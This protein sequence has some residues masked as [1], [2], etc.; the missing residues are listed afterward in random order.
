MA[1]WT[2]TLEPYIKVQEEIKTTTLTPTAGENLIIGVALI[3]DAGPSTPTLI[4]GQKEF[5]KTYASQDLTQEYID[6]L[7]N[8]Y[9]GEDST[10]AATMWANA[11]RL[12]GSNTLLVTRAT[13]AD[14]I[15]FSKPLTKD[16]QNTYILRDGE[17]LKKIDSGFKLVLDDG[18]DAADH[19]TD[20]WSINI[21][22]VGIF[23]N[24]TTDEGA[25]Y[26]YFV[27][28]LLNN[29]YTNRFFKINRI[30]I[31]YFRRNRLG[32]IVIC[33]KEKKKRYLKNIF[34]F[35]IM[36]SQEGVEP[37]TPGL[38]GLCSI[39]LSY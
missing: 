6:S 26:D 17:L 2:Q 25:Q 34:S 12:A 30:I 35:Y 10:T 23:G 22:G 28:T 8:L 15:F 20:G 7:N 5:L 29:S 39:Q 32:A 24:R 13:K 11:Y 16:D 9:S 36:V 4:P 27:N 31:S 3:S 19:D 33:D 14:N 18:G 37:P 21:S 1:Q 38:E